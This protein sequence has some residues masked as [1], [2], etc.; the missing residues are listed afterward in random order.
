MS[1]HI[2]YLDQEDDIVSIRDRLQ[3][4]TGQRVMLVLPETG[5]L[6]AERLDLMRLRRYADD[7]QIE[8]LDTWDSPH[9]GQYPIAWR[10][11]VPERQLNLKIDPILDAQELVTT[12]RYWEGAV[13]VSGENGSEAIFGRGYVELTGYADPDILR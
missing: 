7:L 2:I 11:T 13:D 9:G 3:W 6:L 12:V 5:E 8:V 10:I 4:A 1:A